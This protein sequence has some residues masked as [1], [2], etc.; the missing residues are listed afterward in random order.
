MRIGKISMKVPDYLTYFYRKNQPMFQSICELDEAVAEEILSHDVLWR[1]DGTYLPYR[2]KHDQYL[3]KSFIAKGGK[4]ELDY[5]VYMILGDS[6]TGPHDMHNDFDYFMKIPLSI[7]PVETVSYTYP[8]SMYKV[9]L[10]EL[11]KVHLE[12]DPAPQV[13]LL[14]DIPDV[15]TIYEVY[16]Y[17]NHAIEAQ[18]WSL[19][20]LKEYKTDFKFD[21][22]RE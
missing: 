22:K 19:E 21:T 15:I 11:D 5:P 7:F 2:K 17:N 9:P 6:P 20:P 16:K 10:D 13:Y 18:I 1:G 4:P 3:R 14:P 8:D 12:R